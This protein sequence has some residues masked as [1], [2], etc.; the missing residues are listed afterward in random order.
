MRKIY[1]EWLVAAGLLSRTIRR[2]AIRP[3]LICYLLS[4]ICLHSVPHINGRDPGP[5]EHIRKI[6]DIKS[7]QKAGLSPQM[8]ARTIGTTGTRKIAVILVNFSEAGSN[9]SGSPTM[10]TDDIIGFNTTFDYFKNFYKEASY[11]QLNLD[12]T[13]F[14]STGSATSLSGNETPFTLT[15]PM[16]TY[17]ADTDSSL[18]QL[19][20]DALNVCGNVLSTNYDGVMVAHAGYGNESTEKAGDIWAAYVGPFTATFGFTEGTNVAAKEDSASNIGVACHEFGH[21]LGLWDLYQTIG[22]GSTQ[23]GSWSLMDYGVWLGNPAGSK[24]SHPSSWEKEKL[25]WLNYTEIS[26]GTHNLSSYAFETSAS[27]VYKLKVPDTETEYF[28]VYHTSKTAYSPSTYGNGLLIW[29]IDEGT[30]D[31]TT[32]ADRK[33]NNALN[34][35]SHRT[36]DVEEADDTDPSKTWGD[37]GDL[38]P[39]T[40]IKQNFTPSYSNRYNGQPSMVNVLNISN[41]VQFSSFTVSY[42]PFIDGYVRN[43]AGKGLDG[44]G[45]ILRGVLTDF[46]TTAT[47]GYYTFTDLPDGN[48][49]ITPSS[50]GW[51]FLP[52][53]KE[54]TISGYYSNNNNFTGIAAASYSDLTGEPNN[55][56]PVNNLFVPGN[57]KTTVYYK[58]AKGGKVTIKLYTLDGRLVKTLLNE[59]VASGV[60]SVEWDGLNENDSVVAS[61]IYLVQIIAPD[62]REIKKICVIR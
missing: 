59:D 4:P 12:I 61:G 9:T 21:H 26:S 56:K 49:K 39:G 6:P 31:G 48:Y 46:T 43:A 57:E 20:M 23:V 17:G 62:Y 28:V 7:L 27:S 60:G 25:G 15:T 37:S 45:V 16:S 2:M 38:W 19:V 53:E 10:S 40:G 29:H 54:I 51:E 5:K 18:S 58:T 1:S 35:Y 42:K 34:N 13:F 41:Y 47:G 8:I 14:H 33:T 11:G 55:I 52:K 36:V 22:D 24:P 30:I 50:S 3:L 44:V 32:F